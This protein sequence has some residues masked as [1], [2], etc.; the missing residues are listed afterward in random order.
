MGGDLS[1]VGGAGSPA[2]VQATLTGSADVTG[3][4][5]LTIKIEA[6][7]LIKAFHDAQRS[8][9]LSGRLNP[10]GTGSTG[11]SSPDAEAP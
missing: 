9:S 10:N 2:P 3:E 1:A 5:A 11:R 8:I 4:A 7:E 6:P